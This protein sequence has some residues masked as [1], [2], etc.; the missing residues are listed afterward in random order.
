MRIA[1]HRGLRIVLPFLIVVAVTVAAVALQNGHAVKV[2]W[3]SAS[4][5]PPANRVEQ[6][7]PTD[8]RLSRR[9]CC[10]CPRAW[11]CAWMAFTPVFANCFFVA[12]AS[13]ADALAASRRP[14]LRAAASRPAASCCD[15]V[16]RRGAFVLGAMS[17]L[18]MKWERLVRE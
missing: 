6:R 10:R 12:W 18:L 4:A 9:A 1:L 14:A 5:R 17:D 15:E 7:R 16:V 11:M 3:I 2:K 8:Q 13:R